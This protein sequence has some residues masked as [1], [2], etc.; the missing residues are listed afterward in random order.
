MVNTGK[1]VVWG[2]L[3]GIATS[4]IIQKQQNNEVNWNRAAGLGLISAGV[5]ILPDI[6]EP[7]DSPRHRA[8]AH[9]A[10]IGGTIAEIARKTWDSPDIPNRQKEET[11]CVALAYLS[12]LVLDASTPAS[13]PVI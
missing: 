4:A 3:V 2:F 10:V 13:L 5:A 11:A 9:S 12:H 6:L 7:A 1:H 8:F